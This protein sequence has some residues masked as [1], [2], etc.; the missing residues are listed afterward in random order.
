MSLLL[1]GAK[2]MT[3]AGTE[4]QCLEI[5]TGESYTFPISFT[6]A[7]GNP[8]NALVPNTWSIQPSAKFYT[9][10]DVTYVNDTEVVLGNLTLNPS[11]PGSGAY[12]LVANWTNANI[13]TAYLYVG[14]DITNS[15]NG[16]PTINLANNAANSAL[17]IVTLTVSKQSTANA[18]LADVNK[19]PLGFI[20][21][22]Q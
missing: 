4:M 21:R 14:Y 22:Y 7:N 8:A 9:V 11:Q 13:G 10:A 17:V 2:T 15:G 1:N 3:I 20:V 19:E 12:T 16:T 18:S 6:D 5:Y